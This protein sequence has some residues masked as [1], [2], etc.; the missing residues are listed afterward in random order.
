[1]RKSIQRRMYKPVGLAAAS[2]LSLLPNNQAGQRVDFRHFGGDRGISTGR[3]NVRASAN[4][5]DR[6]Q[7]TVALSMDCKHCPCV[8][9]P[10]ACRLRSKIR[11]TCEPS[12]GET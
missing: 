1:M 6:S 3:Q 12:R 2:S 8:G 7:A 5:L 11:S 10:A 4:Q 9:G